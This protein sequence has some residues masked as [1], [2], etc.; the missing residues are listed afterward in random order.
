MYWKQQQVKPL[1]LTDFFQQRPEMSYSVTIGNFSLYCCSFLKMINGL[2]S[3]GQYLWDMKLNW[4]YWYPWTLNSFFFCWPDSVV[5]LVDFILNQ[6]IN[7][8]LADTKQL[9]WLATWFIHPIG[10]FVLFS[11]LMMYTYL[12]VR[13]ICVCRGLRFRVWVLSLEH[14]L[15]P[16]HMTC[17]KVITVQ[18]MPQMLVLDHALLMVKK[19]EK[20]KKLYMY[21]IY[22][23][24]SANFKTCLSTSCSK[25]WT[26]KTFNFKV[27]D[28]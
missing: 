7:T 6:L 3:L 21:W 26:Y 10:Y 19:K 8:V 4:F 9:G 25:P 24:V 11:C 13:Q 23:Q 15:V 14:V 5:D 27:I 18:K 17:L 20:K 22:G 12:R 2:V 16:C 28:E 1:S